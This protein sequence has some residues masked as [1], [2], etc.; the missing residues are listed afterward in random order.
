MVQLISMGNK[1]KIMTI[2]MLTIEIIAKDEAHKWAFVLNLKGKYTAEQAMRESQR[3]V[4]LKFIYLL[5]IL[6]EYD[7]NS[8]WAD[9]TEEYLESDIN[10]LHPETLFFLL[11]YESKLAGIAAE[12]DK[13]YQK[14]LV[15]FYEKSEVVKTFES[16]AIKAKQ[17]LKVLEIPEATVSEEFY[18]LHDIDDILGD[19]FRP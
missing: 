10:Y 8:V 1:L 17:M 15:V 13:I 11:S 16:W 5:L 6:K 3:Y 9:N 4:Y 2:E 18:E 19:Y 14:L 12:I 7:K